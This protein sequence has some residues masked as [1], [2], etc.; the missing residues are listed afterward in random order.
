MPGGNSSV[1]HRKLRSQGGRDVVSNLVLLCGSG[2]SGCHGITHNP[3]RGDEKV[4]IADG[5]I[6]ESGED[7]ATIAIVHW[8]GRLLWLLPDGGYGQEVAA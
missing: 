7:P 6:V 4:A 3:P 2:S 5:W 1:H 8:S